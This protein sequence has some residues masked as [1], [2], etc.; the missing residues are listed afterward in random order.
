MNIERSYFAHIKGI[1]EYFKLQIL[2]YLLNDYHGEVI[3]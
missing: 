1:K 2:V 3:S